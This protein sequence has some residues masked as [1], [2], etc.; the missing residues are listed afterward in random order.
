MPADTYKGLTSSQVISNRSKFGAN[1]ALVAKPNLFLKTIKEIVIQPM[2][3]LLTCAALLYFILGQPNEATIMLI[4]IGFVTGISIYQEN[5]SRNAINALKK[6][7]IPGAKVIRDGLTINISSADIVI[8]DLIVVEDGDLVPADAEIIEM[9]DFTVN[10]SVL[11]GESL[12][13]SKNSET[14]DHIIFQ[15]SMIMTGFCIARVT[16]IGAHTS[17]GKISQ[18]LQEIEITNTPLQLQ[19]KNFVTGMAWTGVGAFLVVWGVNYY[20]SKSILNGLLHGL[21]M[22]MS[23]LPEEIPVAFSTFMALGAFQL[24]KSKVITR[25]P[26]TVE[27]LGAATV[28]CVD[29]TGTIT[30][31][32]M[33]LST[34]Y[35]FTRD[36]TFDYTKEPF[37]FNTV[38]E[39]AMWSSEIIP[40]DSMEK[41]I[42]DMYT[43]L[44]P[45]DLRPIFSMIHEYPLSGHPPFMTHVF[46]DTSGNSIIAVKGSVEGVLKQCKL[47]SDQK[48]I[49]LDKT[50]VFASSGYRVLGVGKSQM[51]VQNLP[52]TQQEFEFDFLGLI[53]FYDPPKKNIADVLRQFY[54]AGIKV[55]LITG[56]YLDTVLAIAHQVHFNIGSAFLVGNDI[57]TM[58]AQVLREKVNSV[59]IFARMFPEAKLKVI[60]AL[61]ANGEVVAMTGDGVND[62]P[63]LKAA[64]IGVAMGL[65]G[66]EIARQ[67]SSL[68]LMDDDL[69]H[70]TEAIALGRRIYENL[71]KA[72]QYIISIHIPI[73]LIITIPLLFLWKFS[74]FFLPVHVIFL[75]LIMGPTCSIAFAREPMESNSM[76][77][78]PRKLTSSFF[79]LPELTLSLIQGSII[80][81]ACLGLGYYY[82]DTLHDEATIRTVIYTTL[83]FSNI[84][85]T[86]VNRSFHQSIFTTIRYKNNLILVIILASLAIFFMSI[87]FPPVRNLFL[88]VKPTSRD[89]ALCISFAFAGVM[90][91]EIFKWVRRTKKK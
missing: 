9:H 32:K 28:I 45:L 58:D 67:A 76:E 15:G 39:Y 13:V 66:S 60:E 55:K 90:W 54:K 29:K 77:K 14:P 53:A 20:L 35:D 72:I 74:D 86:L 68:V 6:L 91:V 61:K 70:M 26:H 73:I 10:E 51:D 42:H 31:N 79:T 59:N 11:T 17:F 47:S 48:K 23:V 65:R 21:T 1:T 33:A 57:M 46:S 36:L 81:I 43:A 8:D 27:S 5:K 18:S 49:I 2:I 38:L 52:Q 75:E 56:D 19:I 30:E 80:T 71:K 40:F 88:F 22:A 89:L 16:A 41:A 12:P 50:K 85:L 62:G 87:Y 83:I 64:H 63:A 84:F 78:A 69:I 3:I 25:S 4:A 7:S 44:T 82:M 37:Q 34:I 24:Y